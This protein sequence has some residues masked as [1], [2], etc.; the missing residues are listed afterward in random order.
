[1]VEDAALQALLRHPRRHALRVL[2]AD[3]RAVLQNEAA[4]RLGSP[5]F[6]AALAAPL[7]DARA[8]LAAQP[9]APVEFRF[10]H[11]GRAV[12]A[13]LEPLLRAGGGAD[14]CS[15]SLWCE[16]D[17]TDDA[18]ER[19][20]WQ[21]AL[22]HIEDG[23]WDWNTR[24]G[25]VYRTPR[26][27]QML[28][29]EPATIDDSPAAWQALVH[30]EDIAAQ[31]AALQ[32][33]LEGEREAYQ[34][35]YR[36]RDARGRWRWILDRGRVVER[37]ADGAPLRVIGIHTDITA[38]KDLESRL[39]EREQLLN[40]AQRQ[41]R[42]GSWTWDI[43]AQR[44]RWSRQLF[45]IAGWPA[46]GAAPTLS[47]QQRL[48]TPESWAR[49]ESAAR[50]CVDGDA[51][52]LELEL[53]RADDGEHRHVLA[54]GEA[55]RDE[56]GRVV[57][58]AGVVQDVT[59]QRLD[60]EARR[61]ERQLLDRVSA[62][63][64]IGGFELL[65]ESGAVHL[66]E[67]CG[68]I[69][70]VAPEAVLSAA[71]VV[72]LYAPE[73]QP[74]VREAVRNAIGSGGPFDLELELVRSSGRRLWIRTRGE[75]E[76]F[77]GRCVRLFGTVQDITERR[78][79]E[80]R[81]AHLAHYDA[82]TGLPNRVLFADRAQV[83]IARARR[84]QHPLALLFVDL[85]NFKIVNDSL[86]HA[87]GDMLLKEVARRFTSCIRAADTVSR[88]GG[89]EF[90]VL[91]PEIRKP[92]DA[93]V[94]AQK[95][96]RSLD[97]PIALPGSEAAVGCSIGIALL[98]EQC[99]DL[100]ALLRNADAAM[101]EAKG[102]GRRRYR[103]FSEDLQVRAHRRLSIEN[104]LRE[105]LAQQR[106]LLHYQPQIDIES[107]RVVGLE[108][109]LRL[110]VDGQPARS[111][112]EFIGTAEDS[113]LILPL[114]EWVLDTACAQLAGWRAHGFPALRV[115]MNVSVQQLRQG[116]FS[117]RLQQACTRHGLSTEA[118]EIELRESVLMEDPAFAQ[119]VLERLAE[120]GVSVAVDDFGTG[121]SNLAHLRRFPLAR[122]KIDRGFVATLDSQPEHVKLADAIVALGHA[123][124]MRVIAE[125]VESAQALARLRALGCDEAQGYYFSQPLEA[126]AVAGWLAGRS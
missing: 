114:G 60:Q 5:S 33:H 66:T 106:F 108:A 37:D 7:D 10:E 30:P 84:A 69:L 109:L 32:A 117:E 104:E 58:L 126:A 4:D 56:G 49:L 51:F 103:F 82:L 123:L 79:A 89:D 80:Q 46:A 91:L 18:P 68:R 88:Q 24:T 110:R 98:G 65:P 43:D 99:A 97:P 75:A 63:G 44:M 28:G 119:A 17:A 52:S 29:Y 14:G 81:I 40:Q 54:R 77:A 6:E 112:G 38:Y 57:R 96:I 87:A 115:A 71:D 95:L 9:A 105:A 45:R 1:M 8:R 2:D 36:A 107:G 121:F 102:T 74:V 39:R 120:A 100:E 22:D 59:E 16:S 21:F 31:A 85:D 42:L 93:A 86:G 15:L 12:V 26:C 116:D 64:N 101:Y 19:A 118:I 73:S 67:Q 72:A 34:A 53:V 78:Q 62:L 55:V 90:L 47:E 23:L 83:A 61:R 48:Y 113:G 125:G 13:R 11:E 94:I 27:L 41:A 122:L 3:G 70:D 76:M 111:A 92:E 35:E 124:G 20:R 25:R 50:R